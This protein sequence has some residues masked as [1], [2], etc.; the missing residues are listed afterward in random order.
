[1]FLVPLSY[2]PRDVRWTLGS[3]SF[4]AGGKEKKKLLRKQK[5]FCMYNLVYAR[6]LVPSVLAF[7]LSWHRYPLICI[8]FSSRF[9]CCS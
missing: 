9:T 3:V 4:G 5:S 2:D 8:L 6:R 7:S 1:M